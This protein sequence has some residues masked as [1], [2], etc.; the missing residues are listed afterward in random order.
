MKVPAPTP[1]LVP[2]A[3]I[4]ILVMMGR[5]ELSDSDQQQLLQM[6]QA[7]PV[8]EVI[9][10]GKM[11]EE[12]PPILQ[13]EPRLR[14]FQVNSCTPSL[15]AEAGAFEARAEVL[16]VLKTVSCLNRQALDGILLALKEGYEFGGLIRE[17]NRWQTS[18]LKMGTAYCRGLFWFGFSHAYF[19]SKRVFYQSGGFKQNGKLVSFRE[20]LCKQEQLSP[21][22]FIIY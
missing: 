21:Y 20:L 3:P 8:E 6:A 13:H 5:W 7:D 10:L 9:L 17:R 11:E 2:T 19:M 1:T 16:L 22:K 18:L 12:L 14:Q 4:S 15:M